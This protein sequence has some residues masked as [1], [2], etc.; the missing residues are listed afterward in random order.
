[1]KVRATKNGYYGHERRREGT[2]FVLRPIDG[3]TPQ[4][5]PKHFTEEMQ[6]SKK[7]MVKLDDAVQSHEEA[8]AP[9]SRQRRNAM[10]GNVI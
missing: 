4:G 2:E 7:W 10:D 9:K 5:E 3:L 8:A 6:F 1:M